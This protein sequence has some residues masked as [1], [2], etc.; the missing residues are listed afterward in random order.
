MEDRLVSVIVPVYNVEDYINKCVKT[1]LNQSYRKI[2][3]ILVDDGSSDASASICDHFARMNS[4]VRVIHK[5]NA[6]LSAARNSGLS[7]AKG[8]YISFVDGDDY[9]ASDYIEFLLALIVANDAD[10]SQCGYYIQ[11]SEKRI[12]NK[13]SDDKLHILDKMQV[14]ESLCYNGLYDVTA[15][16][17]MYRRELFESV[18]YPEGWMYEDTAVSYRIAENASKFV[19][20]VKPK[21]FYVQRYNSIA[22][23]LKFNQ[24]KYQFVEVGDEM[25]K[26]ISKKYPQLKQAA[27]AKM[28]FVRLSTLAQ[29]VNTKH[30]DSDRVKEYKTFI[31]EHAS[32]VL[33]DKKVHLR[34]KLGIISLGLGYPFFRAVW[35]L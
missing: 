20:K 33:A 35:G 15:W 11:F 26:Y 4:R 30:S 25:A 31:R 22:N 5:K 12:V 13:L 21:Y 17:K 6:G 27:D 34:D 23:G 28:C 1:I 16:N 18:T 2:E 10:I 24:S 8:D 19:I 32:R 29:M 7:L 14:L 9:V 3:V